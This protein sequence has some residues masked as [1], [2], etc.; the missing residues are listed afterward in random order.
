MLFNVVVY[1]EKS[2]ILEKFALE[3]SKNLE[4]IDNTLVVE[5]TRIPLANAQ[6]YYHLDFTMVDSKWI[7]D[8]NKAIHGI[9]LTHIDDQKKL[10]KVLYLG[11]MNHVKLIAMSEY[12]L[13]TLRKI[14]KYP[15]NFTFIIPPHNRSLET[16]TKLKFGIFSNYYFDNRKNENTLIEVLNQLSNTKGFDYLELYIMGSDW[17]T[18]I[19][20][21]NLKN[22]ILYNKFEENLYKD[23][24]NKIDYWLYL[25]H[26]E[27]SMSFLDAVAMNKNTITISQGFH[28]D[29]KDFITFEFEN[30]IDLKRILERLILQNNLKRKLTNFTWKNYTEEIFDNLNIKAKKP[31]NKIVVFLNYFLFKNKV[32]I[33]LAGKQF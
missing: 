14:I 32:K 25:G 4:L 27:G 7:N 18:I 26:D 15:S 30:K 17:E 3:I 8:N 33:N 10:N 19:P 23:L 9:M 1:E 22:I 2:W 6:Y 24:L 28:Y 5:I 31:R 13:N 12:M 16:S 29:L 21:I 20:R 11:T